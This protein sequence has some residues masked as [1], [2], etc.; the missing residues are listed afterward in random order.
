MTFAMRNALDISIAVLMLMTRIA[1]SRL[2]N[3]LRFLR[4]SRRHSP[5]WIRPRSQSPSPR[6]NQLVNHRLSLRAS[7][8]LGLGPSRPP[9]RPAS[10]GRGLHDS[11][12]LIPPHSRLGDRP[13]IRL[14]NPLDSRLENLPHS[15]HHSLQFS[16]LLIRLPNRPQRPLF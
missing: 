7:R 12:S 13:V 11:L 2:P 14:S 16:R 5:R 3:R 1:L 6:R 4:A 15:L 10:P 9:L 8:R